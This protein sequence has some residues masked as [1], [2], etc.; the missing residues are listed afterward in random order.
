MYLGKIVEIGEK[1]EIFSSPIHPYTQ[2]LL[3]S[4]PVPNP[5]RKR[6]AVEL[7]G[8]VPSAINIPL[9]CRFHTR[10]PYAEEKCK[11]AEPELI[12]VNPTHFVACQIM[13][14]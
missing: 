7:K 6:R 3:S 4:I 8:E 10:C 5:E 9:G 2:A 12:A 1:Q 13:E 14:R 11:R